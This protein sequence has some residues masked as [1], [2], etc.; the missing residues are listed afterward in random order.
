MP[1]NDK[2]PSV[3]QAEPAGPTLSSAA[4]YVAGAHD[5]LKSVS[6]KHGLLEKHPELAEAITK[7]ELALNELTLET[8]GIL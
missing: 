3:G 8:G 5:L 7:L 2:T 6:A 4:E 1:S